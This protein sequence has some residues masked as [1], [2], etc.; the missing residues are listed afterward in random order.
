MIISLYDY[1]GIMVQPWVDAEIPAAI[2]DIQHTE[3]YVRGI[4][5]F[6]WDISAM[7]GHIIDLGRKAGCT[8][9]SAFPPCTD[10]AVS[11]SRHFDAK[12]R[13]NPYYLGEALNLFEAAQEIIEGIGCM[14]F[15]ENPVS[16]ASTIWRPQDFTFNPFDY[17]GY[18]PEDD[19]HPEYPDYIAPRD[20]Y[21]KLTCIWAVNGYTLPP[22]KP[23]YCPLGISTQTSQLGGKSLKTKNIRSA[24]PRGFAYANFLWHSGGAGTVTPG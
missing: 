12:M 14:G 11:G 2:F 9:V 13:A 4:P 24:T 17:G 18:L 7:R 5:S 20:A 16:V 21:P 10:L 22:K 1:T 8:F 6:D 15:L 23:V 3:Q 19:V